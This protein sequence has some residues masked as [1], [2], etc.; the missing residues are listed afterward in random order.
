MT[1]TT[2]VVNAE[3]TADG[4][5]D[6]TSRGV[7]WGVTPN[8][9]IENNITTDGQGLGTYESSLSHLTPMATYYV[10]AYAT[11]SEGTAY[12]EEVSFTTFAEANGTMATNM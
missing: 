11:N 1:E 6:A 3:V 2:A 7:C 8:P 12:G 4:G 9:T 10:R 5:A